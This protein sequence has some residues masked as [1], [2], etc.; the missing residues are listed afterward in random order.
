MGISRT[1]L[2]GSN[3]IRCDSSLHLLRLISKA[4]ALEEA[5]KVLEAKMP[6]LLMFCSYREQSCMLQHLVL[7]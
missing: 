5:K 1:F 7:C 6:W 2:E 3:S 4:E